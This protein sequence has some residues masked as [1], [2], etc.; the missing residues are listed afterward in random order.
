MKMIKRVTVILM[1]SLT[2]NMIISIIPG[3]VFL[4]LDKVYAME[5][6]NKNNIDISGNTENNV[7]SKEPLKNEVNIDDIGGSAK[8]EIND[9]YK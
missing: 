9:L 1:I 6:N 8:D 4:K 5:I 2:I 7:K 3:C